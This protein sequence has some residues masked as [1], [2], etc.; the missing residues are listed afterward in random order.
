[1]RLRI[2]LAYD[3]TDFYGWAAQPA[4]RTVEG[5]LSAAL[6]TVLREP[7]VDVTHGLR[8]AADLEDES[9]AGRLGADG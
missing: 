5:V 3:G 8:R 2:D 1:M 7:S 9:I 4:L 6:A